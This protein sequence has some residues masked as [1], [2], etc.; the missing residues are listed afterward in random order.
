MSTAIHRKT[1]IQPGGKI[2]L[3]EPDLPVGQPVDVVVILPDVEPPGRPSALEVLAQAPGHRLFKTAAE[4]EA[5][6]RAERDAWAS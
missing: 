3:V 1:T 2:E 6:L 4:V 5:Y